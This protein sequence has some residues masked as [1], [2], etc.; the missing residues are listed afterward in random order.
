MVMKTFQIFRA[1][2]FTS[3]AGKTLNFSDADIL[4]M[5]AS[6]SEAK[7]PANLV[8]GHPSDD[9]PKHGT[10]KKLLAKGGRLYAIADVFKPLLDLVKA[11]AYQK[12]SASFVPPAFAGDWYLRHVGFLGAMPPA[13]K[14]M[15]SLNFSDSV[16]GDFCFSEPS[17]ISFSQANA[18]F[19]ELGDS[20]GRLAFHHAAL[21]L[22]KRSGLSYAAAAH[23]IDSESKRR[24]SSAS[25]RAVHQRD[26]FHGAVMSFVET[27]PDVSYCEAVT[28][29]EAAGMRI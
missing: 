17:S 3:M 16:S 14:G 25:V 28:Y 1:G 19:C 9:L 8:I 29:I 11:G 12:V 5:A 22:E 15:D 23:A 13:V 24:R 7:R 10:V 27:V 6:Y 26:D 21:A 4:A 2:T 18:D 20:P